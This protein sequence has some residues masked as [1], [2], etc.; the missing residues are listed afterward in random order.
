MQITHAS[1]WMAPRAWPRILAGLLPIWLWSLAIT[2]EGFP[3]PPISVEAAIAACVIAAL[4]SF[5]LLWIGW[6]TSELLVYS[7]VPFLLVFGFDEISTTYKTPFIFACALILSV[8]VWIYQGSAIARWGRGV[9]LL[10]VAGVTLAMAWHAAGNFWELTDTLGYTRCFPDA[11]G[12]APLT[13][14]ELPWWA[15]FF[16]I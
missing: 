3:R 16:S 2:V 13:G 9:I 5:G 7:L 12:C 14:Q 4:V 11:H 6:M 1:R 10:A 15:V 8:G